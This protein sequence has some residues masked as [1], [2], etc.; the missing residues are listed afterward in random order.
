MQ[1]KKKLS[2]ASPPP[3]ANDDGIPVEFVHK[4]IKKHLRRKRNK[5]TLIITFLSLVLIIIF[6][7]IAYLVARRTAVAEEIHLHTPCRESETCQIKL[8]ETIPSVLKLPTKHESISAHWRKLIQSAVTS[9][10]M[11][12]VFWTLKGVD[13]PGGPWAQAIIGEQILQDLVNAARRGVRIRIAQNKPSTDTIELSKKANFEVRTIDFKRLLNA[14]ILH[15]KFFLVD[16]HSMYI[17]SANFDWRSFTEVKELGVAMYECPCSGQ[18]VS[19]IFE[20]NWMLADT[21]KIPHVWPRKYHT[22]FNKDKP[23]EI[24][25][26][27]R[28]ADSLYWSTSPPQ[29]CPPDRTSDIEAILDLIKK[30]KK[31]VYIA[32]MDYLAA[33]IYTKPSKYWNVID[34][35]LREA[36]Y[37]RGIAVRL[38]TSKWNHTRK[39]EMVFL[40]SLNEFGKL[41]INTGSIQVKMFEIP[42]SKIPYSRVNHNKYMVTDTS[43]LISTSNWS[44]DYFTST[45]GI[46]LV[47]NNVQSN[48]TDQTMLHE[49]VKD[50]FLRDWNSAYTKELSAV[51]IDAKC[52]GL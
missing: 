12:S 18:D 39:Q 36:V 35:A 3:P 45:G 22:Q 28:V 27:K 19:K 15:T 49:Q 37:N 31:F 51:D 32:V 41:A 11:L 44:G 42:C 17:G 23:I 52:P 16:G 43:A 33:I 21:V 47:L 30:A 8:I 46:S 10:D 9:I 5:W 14:G 34:D 20:T 4:N 40:K 6:I 2:A 29:F 48:S 38:L 50:V 24:V 26:G 7:T 1:W 25:G 13:V